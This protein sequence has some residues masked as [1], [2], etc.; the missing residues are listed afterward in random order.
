VT[1]AGQEVS[2]RYYSDR[3]RS[4]AQENANSGLGLDLLEQSLLTKLEDEELTLLIAGERG[5]T[6]TDED[7][8]AA[9]AEDL[10]VEVGGD[11][12]SFD[13]LYRERLKSTGMS[14]GNYRRLVRAQVADERI[15]EQ[16]AA[17]VGDTGELVTLRTVVLN[18]EET[19]KAIRT[20]I[21]EGEDIGTLAQTESLDLTSR[22]SDGIMAAE[23][24]ALLPEGVRNAIADRPEGE[25]LDPVQVDQTWWVFKIEKRDPAA[26]LTDTQK[27]QLIQIEFDRLLSAKRTATE[28]ERSLDAED[29]EWA[30][31][32]A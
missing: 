1:V 15:K 4:F 10:G 9:I 14:D 21:A 31:D 3:L 25:V 29:L 7:I 24:A 28:I 2:L 23:P 18:S 32:H 26:T 16:L 30:E 11:G 20:R 6:I 8:E 5:I 17:D 22:Q 13:N 19:A 12:S 27:Q